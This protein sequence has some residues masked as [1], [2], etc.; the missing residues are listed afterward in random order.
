MPQT[1]PEPVL[2]SFGIISRLFWAIISSTLSKPFHWIYFLSLRKP[3][4]LITLEQND[5]IELQ[6]VI[7][8]GTMILILLHYKLTSLHM[9]IFIPYELK[10]CIPHNWD[11]FK[12]LKW[13][14]C[15]N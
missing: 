7:T 1:L 15:S 11:H 12:D 5:I 2:E 10:W 9:N 14:L 4:N 6:F 8:Q 13:I 3:Q